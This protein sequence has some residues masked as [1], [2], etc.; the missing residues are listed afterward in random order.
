MVNAVGD[1]SKSQRF[2]TGYGLV[3]RHS[4]RHYTGQI[5]NFSDLSPIC[6]ALDLN[7]HYGAGYG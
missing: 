2:R 3:P 7:S 4:V 6:F 1:H 5:G